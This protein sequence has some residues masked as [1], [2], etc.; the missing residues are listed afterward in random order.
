[1]AL[2]GPTL[3]EQELWDTIAELRTERDAALRVL[4]LVLG[5]RVVGLELAGLRMI[6]T[7]PP[8]SLPRLALAA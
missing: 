8:A 6:A 7:L 3:E 4:A 5:V 2:D 1:M